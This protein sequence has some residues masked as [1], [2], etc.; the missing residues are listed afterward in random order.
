ML[1]L[2]ISALLLSFAVSEGRQIERRALQWSNFKTK[3]GKIYSTLEEA[4]SRRLIWEEEMEEI[5]QHNKEA[6]EGVHSYILG[7]NQ[8]SDWTLEEFLGQMTGYDEAFD[9]N[10]NAELAIFDERNSVPA[11]VDNREKGLVTNVKNQ[12]SCGSCWA[13]AAIGTL[14]GVWAKKKGKENLVRLSE[15]NLVD[16]DKGDGGC[17]GGGI[18][19]ALTWIHNHHGIE[20]NSDYPYTGHNQKCKFNQTLAAAHLSKVRKV[21]SKNEG[22]LK[23]AV[24]LKGP[25]AISLHVN[26]KMKSYHSGVF[27]DPSCS[28]TSPNHAVLVVGYKGDPSHWIIK[29]SWGISWGVKGYINIKAGNNVCGLARSPYYP[30]V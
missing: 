5:E 7:E 2:L 19:S 18:S 15:Q 30:E 3:Y 25:I 8:F 17:G 1:R 6:E 16:C 14:E 29:N 9:D 26:K 23:R 20:K 13:F 28:K 4:N 27:N 21:G 22:M 11:S 10:D 24:A 12:K